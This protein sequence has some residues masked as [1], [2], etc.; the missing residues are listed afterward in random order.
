M[1]FKVDD[2]FRKRLKRMTIA[3]RE[4]YRDEI[5]SDMIDLLNKAK[6]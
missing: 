1:S 4:K 2:D 5:I 3:E 6:A